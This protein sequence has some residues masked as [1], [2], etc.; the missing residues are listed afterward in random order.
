MFRAYAS[1]STGNFCEAYDGAS[2]VMLE[3]GLTL[4][5]MRQL[6][7]T[8]LSAYE[9]CLITH[10]HGDHA[11]CADQIARLG[12]PIFA[13]QGT[14]QELGL[15]GRNARAMEPGKA[16]DIGG[17]RVKGFETAH[18]ARQ[19]MGFLMRSLATGETL[20]Y[21]T[22]T[23]WLRYT[24]AGVQEIAVECNYDEAWLRSAAVDEQQRERLAHTHL[25]FE[26]LQEWLSKCDLRGTRIIWLLHISKRHGDP[27]A[28][29]EAIQ[30]QT[31]IITKVAGADYPV[32]AAG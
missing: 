24:V 4:K 14:L 2:R 11:K 23:S 18:D 6:S 7:D 31:G 1:G 26:R 13:S 8:P 28:Y 10:E 32:S 5:R 25:S 29:A 19:P 27:L 16:Y 9:A 3:C 17:W 22:D 21:S 12:V 15:S 20:M 30:A